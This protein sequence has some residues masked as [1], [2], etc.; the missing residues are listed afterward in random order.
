[1][2][3]INFGHLRFSISPSLLLFLLFYMFF[4]LADLETSAQ[5]GNELASRG[6]T[7]IAIASLVFYLS[8][9][10]VFVKKTKIKFNLIISSLLMLAVW[11]LFENLFY[12][13]FS[14]EFVVHLNMSALWVLS[15]I[16]FFSQ[17]IS[18]PAKLHR[19][20]WLLFL[21]YTAATVYYF[22]YASSTFNRIPVL[23]IVYCAVALLPWIFLKASNTQRY[24]AYILVL[25]AILLS[26][27]RGAI[28]ALPIMLASEALARCITE[29]RLLREFLIILL[30]SGLLV[31]GFSLAD[32]WT[33]GFIVQRF[34][35]EQL[36]DGSGRNLLYYI[37][38]SDISQRDA[39]SFLLGKGAGA[40]VILLGTGVHNEWLEFLFTYGLIGLILYALLIFSFIKRSFQIFRKAP[41]YAPSCCMMTAFYLL[42][43]LISTGYGGYIG[44]LLF[45]FWGYVDGLVSYQAER[46]KIYEN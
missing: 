9:Y 44:I 5:T 2:K 40:N 39:L 17:A 11:I 46:E 14:W 31:L 8:L 4:S 32:F 41:Q 36:V 35:H 42:L 7:H 1:M 20:S 23:N 6:I 27:K 21:F 10:L 19:L 45:G 25:G 26:M 43:S 22:I 28:I 30:I 12:E 3:T 13:K 18:A 24:L 33:E 34:S 29:K 15:Y 38:I 16:F 37:A